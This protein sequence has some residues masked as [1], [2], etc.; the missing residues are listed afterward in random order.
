[1]N[2]STKKR[3][4]AD[5]RDPKKLQDQLRRTWEMGRNQNLWGP[6]EGRGSCRACPSPNIAGVP[7]FRGSLAA[8]IEPSGLTPKA[9]EPSEEKILIQRVH[10][11]SGW[12]PR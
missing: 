6:V 7:C 1:M 4:A 9:C 10:M 8:P 2:L 11:L 12:D 5:S 3:T